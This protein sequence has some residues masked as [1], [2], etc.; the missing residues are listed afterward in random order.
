M[1]APFLDVLL[2][3]GQITVE[4]C[5]SMD[6]ATF[7]VQIIIAYVLTSEVLEALCALVYTNVCRLHLCLPFI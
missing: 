5:S 3:V 7:V 2:L 6:G 4:L 1:I